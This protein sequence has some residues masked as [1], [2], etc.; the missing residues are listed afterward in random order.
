MS[1]QWDEKVTRLVYGV[2]DRNGVI[3]YIGSTSLPIHLLEA[4]HRNYK[5]KGYS[6]TNFRKNLAEN[7]EYENAT[8]C[9]LIELKVNQKQIEFLE[10]QL[11]RALNPVLN[12]D[13]D[14]VASS[15]KYGR[16]K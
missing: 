5:Q 11:I 3:I 9:T 1:V 4:N 2:R 16:Y 8:F 15:I 12:W 14:P 6:E 7:P 13:K 10:G